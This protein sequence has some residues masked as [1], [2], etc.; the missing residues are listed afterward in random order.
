MDFTA[1]TFDKSDDKI[2]VIQGQVL[3]VRH[4]ETT[5]NKYNRSTPKNLIECLPEYIDCCLSLRGLEQ[6]DELAEKLKKIKI[7]YVFC[8]PLF[9]CLQ[10]CDLTLKNHPNLSNLTVIINPWIMGS[11]NSLDDFSKN[12]IKKQEI[13]SEKSNVRFDW[14]FFN[15]LY[16]NEIEKETYYLNFVDNL[17]EDDEA[18]RI[19]IE[20][21]KTNHENDK[22][23]NISD[24]VKESKNS[25]YDKLLTDLAKYFSGT[26]K[27]PESLNCMFQRSLK[28]KNYIKMF[29]GNLSNDDR[30]LV[31]THSSFVKISTSEMAYSMKSISE[32]PEDGKNLLNCDILT[33]D[34][35]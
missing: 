30:L 15:S 21:I 24:H 23:I 22:I 34:I 8:C 11:V 13:F 35:N 14:S 16:K 20:K 29:F 4:P 18:A 17:T 5:Y 25:D 1:Q 28:F 31:F 26:K 27:R 2:N 7:K 19:L 12:I 10:T 33:M 3:C 32:F 6:I 9:R